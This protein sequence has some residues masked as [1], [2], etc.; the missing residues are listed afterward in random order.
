MELGG[1][2][3]PRWDRFVVERFP[4]PALGVSTKGILLIVLLSRTAVPV[5]LSKAL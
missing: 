2:L 4:L 3:R 5:V 1:K